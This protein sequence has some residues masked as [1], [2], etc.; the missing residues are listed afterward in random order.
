[1]ATYFQSAGVRRMRLMLA[2]LLFAALTLAIVPAVPAEAGHGGIA[3]IAHFNRVHYKQ[4]GGSEYYMGE[5]V[6][7]GDTRCHDVNISWASNAGVHRGQY[8]DGQ[9]RW[10]NVGAVW[11]SSGYQSPWK[12]VV[13]N[14]AP[15]TP[16]RAG[17][18]LRYS[19]SDW[20]V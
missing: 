2:M 17:S 18:K 4:A 11:M 12:V 20:R 15:T 6:R 14:V 3:C 9:W 13:S 7:K 19:T 5:W 8:H 1:M 10:S 16:V